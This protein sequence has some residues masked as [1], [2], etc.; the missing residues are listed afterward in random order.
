MLVPVPVAFE[1]GLSP[2]GT[3]FAGIVFAAAIVAIRMR[4]PQQRRGCAREGLPQIAVLV[5]QQGEGAH[6][7]VVALAAGGSSISPRTPPSGGAA[8]RRI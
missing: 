3:A 1:G 4:W 5:A 6:D 2:L 7:E 8:E